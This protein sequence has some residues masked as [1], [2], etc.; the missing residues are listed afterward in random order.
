MWHLYIFGLLA[1]LLGAN[2]VP[3][4][5]KGI[6]REKYN[7]PFGEKSSPVVNVIWGWL[8]FAIACVLIYYSHYHTHL[9]RAFAAVAI[10]ALITGL[11]L[12]VSDGYRKK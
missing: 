8:C 11:V 5:V 12:A 1:G 7:T 2:G 10:G 9:L 3:H 4:F 6:T